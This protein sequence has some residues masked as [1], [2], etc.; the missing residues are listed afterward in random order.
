MCREQERESRRKEGKGM[1][2][3]M[4]RRRAKKKRK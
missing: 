1:K 3:V 4:K 2:Q